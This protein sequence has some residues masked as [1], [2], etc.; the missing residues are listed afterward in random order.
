MTD[1][2]YVVHVG[3]LEFSP[4]K[5]VTEYFT[6]RCAIAECLQYNPA[7]PSK[8]WFIPRP[9]GAAG[10]GVDAFV[11]CAAVSRCLQYNPAKPSK[12]WLIPRPRGAAG[13]GAQ[14]ILRHAS[15]CACIW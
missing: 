10:E 5:F 4:S 12:V 7:K 13:E 9:R 15:V 11:L 6:S 3:P 14:P 2:Y 1:D 8:V